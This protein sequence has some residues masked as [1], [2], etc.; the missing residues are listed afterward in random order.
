MSIAVSHWLVIG[1]P[2]FDIEA[3]YHLY[4]VYADTYGRKYQYRYS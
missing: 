4:R 2:C 3:L 1:A